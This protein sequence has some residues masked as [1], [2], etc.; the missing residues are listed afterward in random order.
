MKDLDT[1]RLRREEAHHK[2]HQWV[3]RSLA[4]QRSLLRTYYGTTVALVS[5]VTEHTD[6][7][8]IHLP[9]WHGVG[10]LIRVGTKPCNL[11]GL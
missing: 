7:C 9:M 2:H 10:K 1:S 8:G 6:G 11:I 3:Q 4:R 5:Q